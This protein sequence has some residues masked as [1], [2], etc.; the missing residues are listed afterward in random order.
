MS[1]DQSIQTVVCHV[2]RRGSVRRGDLLFLSSGVT[3]DCR[4]FSS[5]VGSFVCPVCSTAQ[6]PVD[7]EWQEAV[8]K[9]YSQYDTYA[10]AGGREQRV[11]EA[12]SGATIARSDL[13]VQWLQKLDLPADGGQLLDVGCG[14]GAFLKAFSEGFPGWG[15]NGTEF[16]DRHLAELQELDRF[17]TLY[18]GRLEDIGGSFDVVSMVHVLE[19]LTDP[20]ACLEILHSKATTGGFLVVQVPDW[21][22]NPFALAI[23]DHATH[24]TADRLAAI[25]AAAGWQAVGDVLNVVPKELT[26]VARKSPTKLDLLRLGGPADAGR[27]FGSRLEW[28]QS[29]E[30]AARE[31]AESSRNFGLFGTAVAATWLHAGLSD[32]VKF[33]VDEDPFRVGGT[34]LGLPILHPEAVPAGSDV[35]VGM[36][37]TISTYLAAKHDTL[38]AKFHAVPPF[39]AA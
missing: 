7:L 12:A 4:P 20:V 28:L 36:A 6:A 3:S 19:H 24:F 5:S 22:L 38:A 25:A 9:I 29:V 31:I 17:Q 32:A 11:A 27:K 33:L 35:F 16:D 10:A 2:C 13:L 15:L 23:A 37:P 30:E 18:G 8:A 21:S 1:T 39:Q 26:L 14:R 34:H